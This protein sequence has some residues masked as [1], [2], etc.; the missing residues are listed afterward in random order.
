MAD[1][2]ETREPAHVF[3]V[4]T[5]DRVQHIAA[6]VMYKDSDGTVMLHLAKREGEMSSPLVA[7]FHPHPGLTVVRADTLLITENLF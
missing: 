2:S 1:A 3:R 5:C 7:V 6:D 4:E